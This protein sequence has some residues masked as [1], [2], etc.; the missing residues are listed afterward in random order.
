MAQSKIA[1]IT[2]LSCSAGAIDLAQGFSNEPPPKQILEFFRAASMETEAHQYCEPRG[3]GVLRTNISEKLEGFNSIAADPKTEVVVTCGAAEGLQAAFR[4]LFQPGHHILTFSPVY[5]NYFH[6]ANAAG[7]NIRAIRLSEPDFSFTPERLEAAYSPCVR[8]VL[9]CNPCNP[10]GKVWS[11][12]ELRTISEF[13]ARHDLVL[14]ADETYERFIWNGTHRSVASLAEARDRTVSIF[15]MGKS[16]SV[17]GWRV[18]YVVAPERLLKPIAR[19][20][21]LSTICA[22]HVCQLALARALKLPNAF[23]TNQRARYRE[24]KRMLSRA[25]LELGLKPWEPKGGYFLWCD[26]SAMS[27]EDDLSFARRLLHGAG[28]A[29]VPG[30]VFFPRG[31]ESTQRIRLTFSKSRKTIREACH[32]LSNFQNDCQIPIKVSA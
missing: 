7:L 19:V 13:A 25:A 28:V 32:R 6:Q 23:Y 31:T 1:E 22:P 12:Q 17:T 2:A 18:G 5:E 11:E 24:R 27:R 10:T 20:R 21:E 30:D 16:Y 26:F 15:S 8:A 29:G 9:L 3:A 14:I 4:A